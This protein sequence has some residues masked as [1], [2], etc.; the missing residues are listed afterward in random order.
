METVVTETITTAEAN[1]RAGRVGRTCAEFVHRLYTQDVYEKMAEHTPAGI[2]TED[3]D[4]LV[5]EMVRRGHDYKLPH[6]RGL[7]LSFK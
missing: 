2:E 5:L 1:Q 7:F 4:A 3:I 6:P